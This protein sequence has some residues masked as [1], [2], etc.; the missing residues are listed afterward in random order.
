MHPWTN[1][2]DAGTGRSF[3]EVLDCFQ[4][5]VLFQRVGRNP[6]ALAEPRDRPGYHGMKTS[7]VQRLAEWLAKS[8]DPKFPR[9]V[10]FA[11][12]VHRHERRHCRSGYQLDVAI[13]PVFK[14]VRVDIRHE[15]CRRPVDLRDRDRSAAIGRNRGCRQCRGN[16]DADQSIKMPL[17]FFLL[18]LRSVEWSGRGEPFGRLWNTHRGSG[19]LKLLISFITISDARVLRSVSKTES[20]DGRVLARCLVTTARTGQVKKSMLLLRAPAGRDHVAR[21]RS[22]RHVHRQ[23]RVA[24]RPSASIRLVPRTTGPGRKVPLNDGH[25]AGRDERGAGLIRH[26][27]LSSL[28]LALRLSSPGR[29]SR[30]SSS[31]GAPRPVVRRSTKELPFA[32]CA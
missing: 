31:I 16:Q 23:G 10:R 24:C 9:Y 30:R 26:F 12:F 17:H 15:L 27:A 25:G 14:N 11:L 7:F 6:P 2:R 22:Q 5:G 19:K 20:R 13:V 18:G 8:V 28:C 32:S 3:E 1:P 4:F 29:R 21:I